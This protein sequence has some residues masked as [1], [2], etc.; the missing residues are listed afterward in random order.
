[1]A[2][3]VTLRGGRAVSARPRCDR[4]SVLS[5]DAAPQ[6]HGDSDETARLHEGAGTLSRAALRGPGQRSPVLGVN[7]PQS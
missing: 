1:M 4:V 7:D 3:D 5:C 6:R 2:T